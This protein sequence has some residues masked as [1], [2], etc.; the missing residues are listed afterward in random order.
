M[1]AIADNVR[2]FHE[3]YG[4]LINDKPTA[5]NP[6]EAQARVDHIQEEVIE[7][8]EASGHGYWGEPDLVEVADALADIVYLCFGSALAYGIDLDA[9]LDAVHISNLSKIGANGAVT[10]GIAYQ[11]PRIRE[12]LGLA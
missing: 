11:R 10:K 9:V 5:I 7:L 3:K 12:A 4:I 8:Y 6:T 1:S 2:E